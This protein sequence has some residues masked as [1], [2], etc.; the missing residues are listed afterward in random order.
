MQALKVGH[1][2]S[3]E[4]ATGITVFLFNQPAIGVYHLCGPSPAT[5][6]V[7]ILNVSDCH[8]VCYCQFSR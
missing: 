2:T 3:Q 1:Y 4:R 7:H 5:R 8:S 6:D